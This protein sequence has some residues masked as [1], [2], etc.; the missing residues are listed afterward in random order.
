MDLEH[1]PWEGVRILLQN[2]IVAHCPQSFSFNNNHLTVHDILMA[3]VIRKR[4]A[5]LLQSWFDYYVQI[6]LWTLLGNDRC[7]L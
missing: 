2:N 6:L 4:R 1:T 5:V 3:N 7:P